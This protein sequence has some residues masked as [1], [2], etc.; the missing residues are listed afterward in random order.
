[1]EPRSVISAGDAPKVVSMLVVALYDP[2][3][4]HIRHVHTAHHHEGAAELSESAAIEQAL[5]HARQLG[6][7]VDELST[8]VS[9]R[10]EH[11][12]AHR[13]DL[14]T[15]VFVERETPPQAG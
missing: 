13:I 7:D 6:H 4:G 5:G 10:A 8:K 1:V 12:H 3:S 15:G 11:A 9:S 14:R 2:E